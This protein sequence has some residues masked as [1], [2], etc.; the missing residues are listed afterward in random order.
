MIFTCA[1][2]LDNTFLKVS[3]YNKEWRTKA[4]PYTLLVSGCARADI[5]LIFWFWVDETRMQ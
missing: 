5:R 2:S 1:Q 3:P 4:I